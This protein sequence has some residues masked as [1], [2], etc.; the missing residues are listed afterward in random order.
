MQIATQRVPELTLEPRNERVVVGESTTVRVVNAYDEPVAGVEVTRDNETV[1]ETDGN[2]ELAVPI[3]STG[4]QGL[5]AMQGNLR[6]AVVAVEG[7]EPAEGST[8]TPTSTSDTVGDA[9]GFG[10]LAALIALA[11]TALLARRR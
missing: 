1:G 8:P 4:S 9:P 7:V 5:Q 2:G 10:A 3:E 6:S 11:A